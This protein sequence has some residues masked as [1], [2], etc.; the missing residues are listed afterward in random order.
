MLQKQMSIFAQSAFCA[1]GTTLLLRDHTN[2]HCTDSQKRN[3]AQSNVWIRT[4]KKERVPFGGFRRDIVQTNSWSGLRVGT[5]S[6]ILHPTILWR[7]WY[8]D[9][10]MHF[11]SDL[12]DY[13]E[14]EFIKRGDFSV[15]ATCSSS[16]YHNAFT[17]NGKNSFLSICTVYSYLLQKNL[18]CWCDI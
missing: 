3:R 11:R 14:F 2:V 5:N 10:G 7:Q 13:S 12:K 16:F 18:L 8:S 6:A 15:C 9:I 17:M 4:P 1:M